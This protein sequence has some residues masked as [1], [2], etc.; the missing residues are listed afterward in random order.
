[1]TLNVQG[2]IA[3]AKAQ[4]QLGALHA[5]YGKVLFVEGFDTVEVTDEERNFYQVMSKA[6]I[7]QG[8]NS[9]E[10]KV[11]QEYVEKL[12]TS[13]QK[14]FGKTVINRFTPPE[15]GN[16]N[17]LKVVWA[18]IDEKL[19]KLK[20]QI[21][22][23]QFVNLSMIATS[24]LFMVRTSKRCL[25][26]YLNQIS[27]GDS[28]PG[29]Y[30]ALFDVLSYISS[31]LNNFVIRKIQIHMR[32]AYDICNK[33]TD[34]LKRFGNSDWKRDVSISY[35]LKKG[36]E[37]ID[38]RALELNFPQDST[39]MQ[40]LEFLHGDFAKY[41]LLYRVCNYVLSLQEKQDE[42]LVDVSETLQVL[43][44]EGDMYNKFLLVYEALSGAVRVI[45]KVRRMKT[46]QKGGK[47]RKQ[48]HHQTMSL[49]SEYL[50]N[51]VSRPYTRKMMRGGESDSL[52]LG[53]DYEIKLVP[54][55]RFVI[56]RGLPEVMHN[57]YFKNYSE[58]SSTYQEVEKEKIK[59]KIYSYQFGPFYA[60]HDNQDSLDEILNKSLNINSII[61]QF[62]NSTETT[63]IV[64]Y[65][66]GY[67]GSG[68]TYTLFGDIEKD[69]PDKENGLVWRMIKML[70]DN[71]CKVF[72][73]R[74]YKCYGTLEKK[75]KSKY[76]E[77]GCVFQDE[78]VPNEVEMIENE[79]DWMSTIN[80]D[81]KAEQVNGLT[82]PQSFIK[83]TSNND[84]SSR[85]FYILQF[86]I[87][88]PNQLQTKNPLQHYLGIV[89][90]AGNEDPFDIQSV[91]LPTLALNK[92]LSVFD[93]VQ[94]LLD[95][96]VYG[97]LIT[98]LQEVI[99]NIL[100][101]ILFRNRG[102]ILVPDAKLTNIVY[103]YFAPVNE[104]FAKETTLVTEYNKNKTKLPK[105]QQLTIN[106][107][108][109]N[110]IIDV[111][112]D[113]KTMDVKFIFDKSLIVD[114]LGKERERIRG[115]ENNTSITLDTI[116]NY[117]AKTNTFDHKLKHM[118]LTYIINNQENI[119]IKEKKLETKFKNVGT[120]SQQE[121]TFKNI[122]QNE[123][124]EFFRQQ[125]YI[126]GIK[127]E[128]P[129]KKKDIWIRHSI[130]TIAAIIKEGYYINQANAE[131]M[132][133]F[134]T[135]KDG[136]LKPIQ[137]ISNLNKYY[138]N[139]AF[140][141]GKY[142][143]F[144]RLAGTNPD[145]GSYNTLLV[146]TMRNI[147]TDNSKDIMFSCLRDDKDFS[148]AKGAIDTLYLVQDIKST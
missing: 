103:D 17:T 11:F 125:P 142:D 133:Y 3:N 118:V 68:K 88:P 51:L 63:S 140:A 1:M 10:L 70:K 129:E 4:K 49:L 96:V 58:I 16:T 7:K 132:H 134:K 124:V 34:I 65:T 127:V 22:S 50:N 14:G 37:Y 116:R 121:S 75:Y 84:K 108:S 19:T 46:Q 21:A 56:F 117:I 91:M 53:N 64:L 130:P 119:D 79:K 48:N 38:D 28:K 6:F 41:R 29:I 26:I 54:N 40:E 82:V 105:I 32:Q 5:S 100:N 69:T 135:K 76:N 71:G 128:D 126:F 36:M 42:D 83:A 20:Y 81:L 120:L 2:N 145:D 104:H 87:T 147:F 60:V 109:N 72:L 9:E 111:S 30:N 35:R 115:V 143:K 144:K 47:R 122:I 131:L 52:T 85:G 25:F 136:Q 137:D 94:T 18:E 97:A 92:T 139:D 86:A 12:I 15:S 101:F 80:N 55:K 61:S 66:Y 24:L 78:V 33:L 89:D 90:M 98:T 59:D 107:K 112:T 114:I 102:N 62:K 67:S 113:M 93:N 99:F 77:I 74:T 8:K 141:F 23:M 31:F 95:D 43:F 39:N 106:D 44:P 57:L 73:K 27:N 110:N 148:K 146:Q 45:V 123:L 13:I 138:F